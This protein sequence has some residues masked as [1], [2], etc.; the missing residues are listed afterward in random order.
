MTLSDPTMA[1]LTTLR[2]HILNHQIQFILRYSVCM[3]LN[4]KYLILYQ[5][6]IFAFSTDLD[7]FLFRFL[8]IALFSNEGKGI[9]Y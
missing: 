5:F 6:V 2:C 7:F 9:F 3:I 8:S 1:F 4:T